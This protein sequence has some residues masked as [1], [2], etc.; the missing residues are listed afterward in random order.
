MKVVQICKDGSMDDIDC[1]FTT[2]NICKVLNEISK[3]QGTNNIKL[4]YS[5]NYDKCTLLCYGWYDGEAGFENKHDL[6]PGGG[7]SF[8][9]TDSSEQLLFGDLFIIKKDKKYLPFEVS[10]YGEFYNFAFEGFD[11]CDTDDESI[12]T[13]E[14]EEE[15][16][17]PKA[18]ESGEEEDCE[19]EEDEVLEEDTTEY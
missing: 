18:E 6:A 3:S 10:D 14:V 11:E 19:Y 4:L 1:K 16:Y 13:E 7:S 17:I 2:K 9:E 12:N 15:D 5:W 8:L